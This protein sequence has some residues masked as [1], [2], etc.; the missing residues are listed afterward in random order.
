MELRRWRICGCLER[1]VCE[2]RRLRPC[3]EALLLVRWR[4]W[5]AV[6]VRLLW[7]LSM[8]ESRA[9]PECCGPELLSLLS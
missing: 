2:T 1:R 4:R 5:A 7:R 8:E 6:S 3:L 9:T